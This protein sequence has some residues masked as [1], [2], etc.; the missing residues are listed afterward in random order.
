ML[1][2]VPFARARRKMTD[3]D[4]QAHTV[5]QALKLPFPQAY[6][7]SVAPAAVGGDEQRFGLG[8]TVS[9]HLPPPPAD[10]IHRK[11]GGVMIH[12]DADPTAIPSQ[13]V[14]AVGDGLALLAV[15]KIV[16]VHRERPAL[17]PPFAPAILEASDQLLL[18]GVHRNHRLAS[19]KAGPDRLVDV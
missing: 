7:T 11:R 5:R 16:N 2:L 19:A 10:G 15:W 3:R 4:R 17:P 13:V 1:N 14:H 9:A 6:P 12:A 8:I 18:L